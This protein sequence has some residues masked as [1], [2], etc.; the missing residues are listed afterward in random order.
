MVDPV[1]QAEAKEIFMSRQQSGN[2]YNTK[3]WPYTSY[4][5]FDSWTKQWRIHLFG[6]TSYEEELRNMTAS[7][8]RDSMYSTGRLYA[9]SSAVPHKH[10]GITV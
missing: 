6:E 1:D 2:H 9:E 4:N 8:Y 10:G 5:P 3:Y 7:G